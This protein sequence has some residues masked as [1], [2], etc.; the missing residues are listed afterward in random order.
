MAVPSLASLPAVFGDIDIYLFD[1]FLKGRIREGMQLLDAGC[2]GGRNL[3]YLLQAGVLIYGA[4]TSETA[5]GEVRQ[6]AKQLAPHVPSSHFTVADLSDLPYPDALF[7]VVICSAVLHFARDEEHFRRIMQE[8][9]RVLKP[10]GMFFSRLS[11]TIGM[12]G[13]LQ[14]VSKRHYLMP[15]GPVWFLASE[16]LIREMITA[17]SAELLEPLKSVL[18][19]QERSMTTWVMM[20]L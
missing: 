16:E 2:G 8:L 5:I 3:H 20:K 14:Q 13:K 15:H 10:G 6:L 7:D 1:Q 17:L 18:V 4:D 11:T 19:E 9:W 12:E